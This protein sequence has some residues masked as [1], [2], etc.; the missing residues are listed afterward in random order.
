MRVYFGSKGNRYF[1]LCPDFKE[2]YAF[3]MF[4]TLESRESS[5]SS[6]DKWVEVDFLSFV[7]S[8][9]GDCEVLLNDKKAVISK[10]LLNCV[11]DIRSFGNYLGTA[12]TISHDDGVGK[13]TQIIFVA[14]KGV[15]TEGMLERKFS[16]NSW[17]SLV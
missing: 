9:V 7:G 16:I 4:G 10:P 11:A 1:I 14:H 2:C 3:N 12:F 6:C 17:N 15:F 5:I 8:G 13:F